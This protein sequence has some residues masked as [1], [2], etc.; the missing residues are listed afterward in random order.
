LIRVIVPEL[1]LPEPGLPSNDG[2]SSFSTTERPVFQT[3]K[4][5]KVMIFEETGSFFAFSG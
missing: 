5:G 1:G 4:V 3:G 2:G